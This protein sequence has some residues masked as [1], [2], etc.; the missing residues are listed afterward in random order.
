M[1]CRGN[2]SGEISAHKQAARCFSATS[3]AATAVFCSMR[4]VLY[5][6]QVAVPSSVSIPVTYAGAAAALLVVVCPL[7]MPPTRSAHRDASITLTAN[8]DFQEVSAVTVCALPP[9]T[10]CVAGF[11]CA[12]LHVQSA[13]QLR[14]SGLPD[15]TCP[16]RD[17]RGSDDYESSIRQA[18]RSLLSHGVVGYQEVSL[19]SPSKVAAYVK[20]FEGSRA[21]FQPR[22]RGLLRMGPESDV[23]ETLGCLTQ[24]QVCVHGY[25]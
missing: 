17:P 18:H 16:A 12:H 4:L 6:T 23:M 5:A 22:V 24:L 3:S 15:A 21:Y 25:I 14:S 19:N 1:H 8:R 13:A 10:V 11:Y 7:L 20:V 9:A 2:W